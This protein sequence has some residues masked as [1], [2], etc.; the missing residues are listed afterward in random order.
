[1]CSF[2]VRPARAGL[3]FICHMVC[4]MIICA[5]V[6]GSS[7]AFHIHDFFKDNNKKKFV[8]RDFEKN[9]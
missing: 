9:R 4:P 5:R 1:M 7:W 2:L 6:C 8:A 3:V